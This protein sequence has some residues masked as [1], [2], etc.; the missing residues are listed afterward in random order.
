MVG[1]SSSL[2]GVGRMLSIK[3]NAFTYEGRFLLACLSTGFSPSVLLL[4]PSHLLLGAQLKSLKNPDDCIG[5]CVSASEAIDILRVKADNE[6]KLL[7]RESLRS[8][9]KRTL[10]D[11][12]MDVSR[13]IN[14]VTDVLLDELTRREKDVEKDEFF[15]ELV[16]AHCPKILVEKY[17]HRILEKL[18][19]A[20]KIAI[21]SAYMASN[22][23]YREGLG[24][25]DRIPAEQRY[26]VCLSYMKNDKLRGELITAVDGSGLPHK[27]KIVAILQRSATRDLTV[28]GLEKS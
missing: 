11:L 7:F 21:L 1:I 13:E 5:C 20:H 24:W 19:L 25:L 17:R 18:P 14:D 10:V 9:G 28:L 27:D 4:S 12:S 23:V 22:I 16:L 6:A 15:M 2:K 8:G 26:Q 3:S